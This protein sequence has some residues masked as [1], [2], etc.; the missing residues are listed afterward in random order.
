M[1][2]FTD[3]SKLDFRFV[4]QLTGIEVQPFKM[5]SIPKVVVDQPVDTFEF[6][7]PVNPMLTIHDKKARVIGKLESGQAI[8][9]VKQF[10]GYSSIYSG[11]PLH[12]TD[13]Y[14]KLLND[15]GCHVYNDDGEFL[16]SGSGLILLHTKSGGNRTIHLR[17]GKKVELNLPSRSTWIL[18]A[19]TG[20]ILLR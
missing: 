17:N 1:P 4:S 13:V 18:D 11:L 10:N 12:G 20:E 5:N 16:Y 9:G 7:G 15:A 3:G 8:I 14:R 2:G 6:E 19:N